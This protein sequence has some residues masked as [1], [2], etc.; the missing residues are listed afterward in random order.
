MDDRMLDLLRL[1]FIRLEKNSFGIDDVGF[2]L[3]Y[4]IE[5]NQ[6]DT[7]HIVHNQNITIETLEPEVKTTLTGSHRKLEAK[8]SLARP[9]SYRK[10]IYHF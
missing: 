5:L 3:S 7:R 10:Q 1:R 6:E 2:N 4:R 8:L 9:T